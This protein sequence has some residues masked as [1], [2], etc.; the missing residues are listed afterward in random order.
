LPLMLYNSTT[1]G[2]QVTIWAKSVSVNSTYLEHIGAAG[3]FFAKMFMGV[4]VCLGRISEALTELG[5]PLKDPQA[6]RFL[7]I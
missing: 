2:N 1:S 3:W 6:R 7:P 5:A 4:L